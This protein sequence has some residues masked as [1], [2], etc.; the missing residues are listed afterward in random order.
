[1]GQAPWSGSGVCSSHRQKSPKGKK[2]ERLLPL[3][4]KHNIHNIW[5]QVKINNKSQ[6]S[7]N[8]N[9]TSIST[10]L[11]MYMSSPPIIRLIS[12]RSAQATQLLYGRLGEPYVQ[13]TIYCSLKRILQYIWYVRGEYCDIAI[14]CIPRLQ[15]I[16]ARK[17]HILIYIYNYTYCAR[18][19]AISIYNIVFTN[20]LTRPFAYICIFKCVSY[21]LNDIYRPVYAKINRIF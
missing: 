15:Y 7:I 12:V 17:S 11:H 5:Y 9:V 6:K 20:T 19:E 2:K 8:I 1:M 18:F 4:G 10:Y 14:Y 3:E 13:Y 16:V 21:T